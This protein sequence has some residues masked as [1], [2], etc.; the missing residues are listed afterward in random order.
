[1][2]KLS[3]EIVREIICFLY[4][5]SDL[6]NIRLVQRTFADIANEFLFRDFSIVHAK[7][8]L[9]RLLYV[10]WQPH[11][12]HHVKRVDLNVHHDTVS[13]LVWHDFKQ[14]LGAVNLKGG[15]QKEQAMEVF[16][17]CVESWYKF[18]GSPEF[19]HILIAAFSHL[20]RLETIILNSD[21]PIW[22]WSSRPEAAEAYLHLLRDTHELSRN[23]TYSYALTAVVNSAYYSHTKI[24]TFTISSDTFGID[25]TILKDVPLLK[26]AYKVFSTC[27]VLKLNFGVNDEMEQLIRKNRLIDLLQS[28]VHLEELAVTFG[29]YDVWKPLLF[30]HI[31]G[32]TQIW[33]RLKRFG[34]SGLTMHRHEFVGFLRRHKA[35]LR[36]I[37]IM[38]CSLQSG[39]WIEVVPVMKE[40]LQ[41]EGLEI[42]CL[43]DGAAS[44]VLK[45]DHYCCEYC[46]R[47]RTC[48]R[49]EHFENPKFGME[50]S[51]SLTCDISNLEII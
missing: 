47:T 40:I 48:Y 49:S 46:L 20:P 38:L 23:L 8:S 26:R 32:S 13:H 28:A 33:P 30:P 31:F 4:Q 42:M 16:R 37:S 27:Q 7:W 3:S 39:L 50:S 22:L 2:H 9:E 29:V 1:M 11:L 12:A 34:L 17:S 19:S 6:K 5:R 36:E 18:Q 44:D 15:S 14:Q 45:D 10:S 35:T 25:D 24:R 41:L 43:S 51:A 21:Q